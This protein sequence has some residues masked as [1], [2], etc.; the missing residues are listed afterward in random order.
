MTVDEVY[1][2]ANALEEIGRASLPSVLGA[3]K[4]SSTSVKARENAVAV[5]MY[6]HR[7]D[8][9]QGITLLRREADVAPD[10]ATKERILWSVKKALIWCQYPVAVAAKCNAAARPG[11]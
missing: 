5:W 7:D 9:P 10:E 11:H 2:A 4:L 6:F 1:P 3:I 8:A